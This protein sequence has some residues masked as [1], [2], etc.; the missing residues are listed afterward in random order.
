VLRFSNVSAHHC[1]LTLDGGYWYVRDLNSSNG[2]KVNGV[3][4]VERR[5]DPG[6]LISFAKHKFRIDYNPDALGATGPPPPEAM[7]A[8]VLNKSLLERAGLSRM[9]GNGRPQSRR[10]DVHN[11]EAG[12]IKDP[13]K[14]V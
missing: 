8:D 12:Q 11:D 4:V 5:L 6:S 10:F 14:P 7:H 2:T 9:A 13:N 3:R 1:E